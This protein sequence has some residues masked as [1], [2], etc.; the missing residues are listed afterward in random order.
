[1]VITEQFSYHNIICPHVSQEVMQP[2]CVTSCAPSGLVMA[3][4]LFL[5]NYCEAPLMEELLFRSG[6]DLHG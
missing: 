2:T 6:T 1:L 4:E 3:N 5:W